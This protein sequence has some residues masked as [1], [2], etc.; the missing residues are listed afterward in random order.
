VAETWPNCGKPYI[1]LSDRTVDI[2]SE[3]QLQYPSPA[4]LQEF[5]YP[6]NKGKEMQPGVSTYSVFV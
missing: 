2:P 6:I 1:K 3:I 4:G 5:C